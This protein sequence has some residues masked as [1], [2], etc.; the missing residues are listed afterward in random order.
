MKFVVPTLLLV[1]AACAN[2]GV[3]IPTGALDLNGSVELTLSLKAWSEHGNSDASTCAAPYLAVLPQDA[4]EARMREVTG[5]QLPTCSRS[6]KQHPGEMSGCIF[7]F[8]HVP[9]DAATLPSVVYLDRDLGQTG[10]WRQDSIR[11]ELFHILAKCALG[12][13]ED[14]HADMHVWADDPATH[15]GFPANWGRESE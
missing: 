5:Y 3:E 8:S 12:D 1:F 4:F 7:A 2:D 9:D 13:E 10:D 6:D 14:D 11:H 15:A